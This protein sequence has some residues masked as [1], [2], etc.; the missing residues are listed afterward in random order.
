MGRQILCPHCKS[1]FDEDILAKRENP[2]ICPVCDE[3]LVDD[4]KIEDNDLITWYYYLDPKYGDYSLWD[5]LPNDPN[6]LTLIKEFK[7]PPRD[8]RG[9]SDKAKDILRT[10]IPDA[11]SPTPVSSM[12]EVRCPKCGSKEYTLLNKGFSLLT[13]FIGSGRIKRVCNYCKREF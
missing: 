2:N 6:A 3:S 12:P 7:A 9:K 5:K 8:E 4:K 1:T 10:Y 11:F 13:G